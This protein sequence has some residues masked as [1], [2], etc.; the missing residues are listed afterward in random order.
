[1]VCAS[2]AFFRF[3]S[4][5]S[6]ADSDVTPRRPPGVDL[7]LRHPPAQRLGAHLQPAGA[8]PDRSEL[9]LVVSRTSRTALARS[10]RRTCLP[11][12]HPSQ[13]GRCA[14]NPGRFTLREPG[15]ETPPGHPTW[16]GPPATDAEPGS[17]VV[18]RANHVFSSTAL[19][20]GRGLDRARVLE[21]RA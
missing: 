2:S 7:G 17:V 5:I 20:G 19:V 9:R 10:P 18:A 12:G 3:S 21:L 16:F 6:L 4:L 11:S 1:M 13:L 8:R 15:G 14:S